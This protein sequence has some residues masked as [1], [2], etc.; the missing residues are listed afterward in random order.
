M[1]RQAGAEIARA[2]EKSLEIREIREIG[3]AAG[4][5]GRTERPRGRVIGV[6]MRA[7]SGR[8]AAISPGLLGTERHDSD[9]GF[10]PI[11]TSKPNGR[12]LSVKS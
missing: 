3:G 1:A 10:W 7:S 11:A 9:G 6:E 8:R 4:V 12:H 2:R 5:P